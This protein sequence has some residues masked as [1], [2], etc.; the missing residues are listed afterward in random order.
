MDS[1]NARPRTNFGWPVEHVGDKTWPYT[2]LSSAAVDDELARIASPATY[3]EARAESVTFQ[4]F[5]PDKN[6]D[7]FAVQAW[8]MPRG[9][10]TFAAVFDG[11]LLCL[12]SSV[13]VLLRAS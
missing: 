10:W 8:D 9:K 6:E 4:P 12:Q 13:R 2:P 11:R 5:S 7:R 3:A 1:S